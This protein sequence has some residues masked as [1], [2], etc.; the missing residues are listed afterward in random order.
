MLILIPANDNITLKILSNSENT[1]KIDLYSDQGDLIFEKS[2]RLQKGDNLIYYD[3]GS[4]I[5]GV[6]YFVVDNGVKIEETKFIVAK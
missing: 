3:L 1:A 4:I 2:I 5:A 6:Y